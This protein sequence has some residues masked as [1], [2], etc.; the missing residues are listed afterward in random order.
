MTHFQNFFQV[1]ANEE[2]KSSAQADVPVPSTLAEG[3]S[4]GLSPLGPPDPAWTQGTP[5]N[6]LGCHW[7]GSWRA[8][9]GVAFLP[10]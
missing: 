6:L 4:E 7:V 2:G 1:F 9:H 10:R 3:S 8:H 5:Q